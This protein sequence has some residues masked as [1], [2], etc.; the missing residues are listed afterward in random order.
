MGRSSAPLA[1]AVGALCVLDFCGSV[2]AGGVTFLG[3]TQQW[4]YSSTGDTPPPSWV[5]IDFDDSGWAAGVAPL[6]FGYGSST[7]V[8]SVATIIPAPRANAYY[9]RATVMLAFVQDFDWSVQ[10]AFGTTV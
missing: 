10:G 7:I 4:R 1:L 5:G 9:F 3:S 6:A 8:G 2:L